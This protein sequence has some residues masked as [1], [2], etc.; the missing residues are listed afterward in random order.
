M[1]KRYIICKISTTMVHNCF[2]IVCE[3]CWLDGIDEIWRV[4]II[5]TQFLRTNYLLAGVGSASSRRLSIS[6]KM[7]RPPFRTWPCAESSIWLL[8]HL[9]TKIDAASSFWNVLIARK[10]RSARIVLVHVVDMH[11]RPPNQYTS[12][13]VAVEKTYSEHVFFFSGAVSREPMNLAPTEAD[14]VLVVFRKP[15]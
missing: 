14:R 2:W 10:K 15:S 9:L 6:A 13:Y 3:T 5:R 1:K 12:M 8:Y 11:I 4:E 7:R